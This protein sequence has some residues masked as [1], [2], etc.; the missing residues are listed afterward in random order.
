M[1]K[2]FLSFLAVLLLF[3]G[4][5]CAAD[6]KP[7]I[8]VFC[9]PGFEWEWKKEKIDLLFTAESWDEFDTFLKA[10]KRFAGNRPIILDLDCHGYDFLA[11]NYLKKHQEILEE[12]S[13]GFLVNHIEK[14]LD[15]S[16]LIVFEEACYSGVVY[17]NSIRNNDQLIKDV[18]P[19]KT[20]NC[21]HIPK[22]PII[23]IGAASPNRGNLVYLQ[24]KTHQFV[25]WQD[26]RIYEIQEVGPK[27]TSAN[28]YKTL[29]ICILYNLLSH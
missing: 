28:S 26:L 7:Y 29:F 9:N 4:Y 20:E 23:G 24:W 19:Q 22:F 13:E 12:A 1:K 8:A 15:T 2:K 21:E 3:I 5:P 11:L 17:K 14:Y 6:T 16:N 18:E 10:V 27:D 25:F